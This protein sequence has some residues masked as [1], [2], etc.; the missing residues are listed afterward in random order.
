MN[1][2]LLAVKKLFCTICSAIIPYKPLRHK[3]RYALNPLNDQRVEQYFRKQ[4]ILPFV[5]DSHSLNYQKGTKNIDEGCEYIWQCWLQGKEQAPEVVKMCL[6]SVEKYKKD[7]QKIIIITSKNYTNYVNLPTVIIEKWKKGVISAAH[8]ADILRVNLLASYGG[9]WIDATCLL[10]APTPDAIDRTHIF[11][12]NSAGEFDF[13]LIQNCFIHATASNYLIQV[14]CLFINQFWTKESKLLH[15]F[16]HHLIFK[17]LITTVSQAKEEFQKM[18]VISEKE[19]QTLMKF[20]L[21]G[22]PYNEQ[23]FEKIKEKSFMH[24]LTYKEKIPDEFIT[25]YKSNI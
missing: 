22:P 8:F 9:Y 21:A 15:Y 17:A 2:K 12:Y 5:K 10:T 13:T 1:Y 19:T 4:Y 20:I 18:P 25:F 23:E 7:N 11:M 16:Q 14:W 3:V 24:K 6:A